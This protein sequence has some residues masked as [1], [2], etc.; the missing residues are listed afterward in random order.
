M[1]DRDGEIAARREAVRLD[2]D[3][4]GYRFVLRETLAAVGRDAEAA[5]VLAAMRQNPAWAADPRCNVRYVA[6]CDAIR[7]ATGQVDNPPPWAERP[8]FRQQALAVLTAER[9]DVRR[10]AAADRDYAHRTTQCWLSSLE[11]ATVRPPPAG[12]SYPPEFLAAWN[13][14]SPD[15]QAAWTAFWESV[16][17]LDTRT[18]P[19][20]AGKN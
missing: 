16:Q 2:P 11:L 7:R 17:D 20:K 6:A 8:A 1:D 5:E 19:A 3:Y 4:L 10:R 9:D 12:P 18:A 15:E 14:M 13:G